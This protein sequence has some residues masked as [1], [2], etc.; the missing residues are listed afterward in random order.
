MAV[1]LDQWGNPVDLK[2]LKE[3]KAAPS[4]T[5]VRSVMTGHPSAGLTPARLARLLREAESGD[6]IRYLEL[7][8][9]MEEKDLHYLGVIGTRKRQV[10]QLDISVEAAGDDQ[11]ALDQQTFLED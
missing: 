7:A 8:E 2:A 6:P 4:V 10:A 5:G 3:E 1:L 9:D 11:A